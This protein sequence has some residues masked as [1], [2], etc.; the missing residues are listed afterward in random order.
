[1]RAEQQCSKLR[2]DRLLRFAAPGLALAITRRRYDECFFA[3]A[4][5]LPQGHVGRTCALVAALRGAPKRSR[6]TASPR[7]GSMAARVRNE[8]SSARNQRSG[9][10]ERVLECS[11]IGAQVRRSHRSR[12]RPERALE[13]LRNTPVPEPQPPSRSYR[14]IEHHL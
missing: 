12:V 11:A 6:S 14:V 7:P 4:M 1:M 8:C 3:R 10:P 13:P 2:I 9:P 5:Y